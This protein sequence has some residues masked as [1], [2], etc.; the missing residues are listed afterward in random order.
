MLCALSSRSSIHMSIPC[1][2]LNPCDD[3]VSLRSA[4]DNESKDYF[5]I[6][7]LS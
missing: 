6:T 1:K 3:L 2:Y 7:A 5:I 4:I